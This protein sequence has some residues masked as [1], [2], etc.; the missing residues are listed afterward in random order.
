MPM[1]I[2]TRKIAAVSSMLHRDD[3]CRSV[4]AQITTTGA[5]TKLAAA[6]ARHQVAQVDA[7]VDA[8][9][10]NASA[11]EAAEAETV[12][13]SARIAPATATIELIIAVGAKQISANFATPV[14]V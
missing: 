8:N 1:A 2:V 4:I 9:A 3:G 7:Q 11:V 5:T 10:D 14:D 6:S 12:A 13:S